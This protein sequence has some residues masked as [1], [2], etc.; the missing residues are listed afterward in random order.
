MRSPYKLL[1]TEGC[2]SVS[3][4]EGSTLVLEVGGDKPA[5]LRV[6]F[7]A[8]LWS[9]GGRRA[10]FFNA[11]TAAFDLARLIGLGRHIRGRLYQQCQV[12]QNCAALDM[13]RRF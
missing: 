13:L 7:G 8:D 3:G 11:R 6:R 1:T 9:E 10:R 2:C 12:P 4:D 5:S